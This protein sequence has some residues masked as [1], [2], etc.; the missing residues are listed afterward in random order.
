MLYGGG[1]LVLRG[2]GITID[3][4]KIRLAESSYWFYLL[5][6]CCPVSQKARV[7]NRLKDKRNR[8]IP[9]GHSSCNRPSCFN[10]Y[11]NDAA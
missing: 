5:I 8:D 2:N 7:L 6:F 11:F 3:D 4:F 10:Y 9:F 1:E